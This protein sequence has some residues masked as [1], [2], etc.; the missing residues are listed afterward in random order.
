MAKVNAGIQQKQANRL[1]QQRQARIANMIDSTIAV[2][3]LGRRRL[4][5]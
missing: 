3:S 5:V 1:L 4:D 2:G